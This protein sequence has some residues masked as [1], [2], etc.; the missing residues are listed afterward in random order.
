MALTA[1]ASSWC[2]QEREAGLEDY[3]RSTAGELGFIP[4][5]LGHRTQEITEAA[6]AIV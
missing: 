3:S 6:H 5:C 2:T 4:A 1:F